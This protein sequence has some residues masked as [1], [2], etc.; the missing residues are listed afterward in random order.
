MVVGEFT[1]ETDLVVIGGG[2][3]G[4]TTALRAAELGVETTIVDDR[5]HL[6]GAWLHEG[7]VPSKELAQV[8]AVIRAAARAERF[9]VTMGAPRVDLERLR[10][11]LTETAEATATRLAEACRNRDVTVVHGRARFDDSRQLSIAGSTDVPRIRFRRA[12]I[13]TG[14]ADRVPPEL[15]VDDPRVTGS[16]GAFA[17]DALPSA[18]LVVGG[19]SAA[20]ELAST[21]AALGSDVTLVHATT[22]LLPTADDDLVDVVGRSLADA[23]AGVH[24]ET[25]VTRLEP[26]DELIDVE[27]SHNGAP[28]SARFRRVVIAVGRG[29]NVG[30]L[31]LDRTKVQCTEDG[32]IRVDEQLRTTDPRIFAVGDVTGPPLLAQRATHQ[33]R[34][35]AE[36]VA[37]WGSAF[38]ARAVPKVLFTEPQIAWCGLTEKQAAEVGESC[39]VAR[40]R[41]AAATHAGAL[42][43]GEGYTKIVYDPDTHLV[44][45]VGIVGPGA[46]ELIAEGALAVEMGAV[47]TDLAALIH[48]HPTHGEWL[49]RAADSVPEP[50]GG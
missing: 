12:V 43:E 29:P 34:V 23:L 9:G 7:C 36:V 31:G 19:S 40:A 46:G 15:R 5:A 32:F 25:A 48:P 27:L 30:G 17:L 8:A 38:D 42:D 39:A 11:R 35:A 21:M 24:A 20:V 6:G 22:S 45:G 14:A 44:L 50:D 47:T 10:A 16:T 33:G 4:Y 37:G 2:P 3:G 13:A 26:G 28:R 49:G 1:V 18:T 41:W